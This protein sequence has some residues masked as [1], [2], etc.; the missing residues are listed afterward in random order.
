[1]MIFQAA[2]IHVLQPRRLGYLCATT[3]SG[4]AG[5]RWAKT[6]EKKEIPGGNEKPVDEGKSTGGLGASKWSKVVTESET[7]AD[8]PPADQPLS[9]KHA[10]ERQAKDEPPRQRKEEDREKSPKKSFRSK[11]DN[12]AGNGAM[13]PR[14]LN[15]EAPVSSHRPRRNF[16]PPSPDKKISNRGKQ[17][18]NNGKH[19]AHGE[20][21]SSK[22]SHAGNPTRQR[23]KSSFNNNGAKVNE[24]SRPKSEPSPIERHEPVDMAALQAELDALGEGDDSNWA[25]YDSE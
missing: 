11:H 7:I 1:M 3:M 21:R 8:K 24:A 12:N 16:D 13:W 6:P 9:T 5:S 20:S 15:N 2:K 18:E 22:S 14:D 17:E 4:L 25:D 10:I 19:R 23:R